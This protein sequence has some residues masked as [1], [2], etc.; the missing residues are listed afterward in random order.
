M[1]SQT[2]AKEESLN[3]Q[4]QTASAPSLNKIFPTS[5]SKRTEDTILHQLCWHNFYS[6][7]SVSY[8]S[9]FQVRS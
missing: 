6:N 5:D 3:V 4:L 7:N 9:V 2:T 1:N 8:S